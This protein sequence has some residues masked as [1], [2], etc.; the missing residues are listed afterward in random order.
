MPTSKTRNPESAQLPA[1]VRAGEVGSLDAETRTVE[2]VFSTGASR[3]MHVYRSGVGLVRVRETLRIDQASVDL[4]RLNAGAPVLDSHSSWSMR[5]QLAVVE[6]ARIEAGKGV[7]RIRFPAPGID[8]DA[9]R[10]FGL[11]SDG[12]ARNV[13]AG[14]RINEIKRTLATDTEPEQWLVTRWTPREISFVPV[15]ADPGAQVRADQPTYPADI[16]PLEDTMPPEIQPAEVVPSGTPIIRADIQPA[17]A[18]AP[19]GWSGRDIAAVGE[20][21]RLFGL[22]DGAALEVI[23]RAASLDAARADLQAMAAARNTGS[24]GGGQPGHTP[25]VRVGQDETQTRRDAVETAIMHRASPGSVQLTDPAR[26]YRSLSLLEMGRM[27]VED[28]QGVSLRALDKRELATVL[29]GFE[30]RSGMH[31]TSDFKTLLSNVVN[32]RLR[33]TYKATPQT[34]RPFCRQS[35]APDFRKRLSVALEGLPDLRLI[36][37]GGEYEFAKLG[38]SGVEW[39]IATYGRKIGIS[40]QML[41][42]DDL[43]AFSRVPQLFGRAL[44]ELESDL[45]WSIIT[46]NAVMADGKTLFHADHGNL[47]SGGAPSEAEM[48]EAEL[49]MGEQLDAAKKAMNL[50]PRFMAVSPKHKVAAQKLLTA[51]TASTTGDVNVYA[52]AV[53]LIVEQRIKPA[54]GAAPW[55]LIASPDQWDTIE[56]G[57]LDGEEG[58]F[59]ETIED[60]DRDGITIKARV[61]FGAKAIDH[62]GFVKNPGT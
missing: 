40:R 3:D 32:K 51:I 7:A 59:T 48:E 41:I 14:Y 38:E 46:G 53:D 18:P 30:T 20:C 24:T 43:N 37:E 34:W 39:S 2:V 61:D 16:L 12:I 19:T 23:S 5:S 17:A 6:S 33:D 57:Y 49:L 25:R 11:I 13:S 1:Q 42:N 62:R 4:S 58:L 35:N 15:P 28:T 36:K 60:K 10:L 22:G 50:R 8:A 56:Y 45:V 47:A 21:A 55:F 52:N 9:D 29:L 27:Y 54:A 44:S 26:E 31:S